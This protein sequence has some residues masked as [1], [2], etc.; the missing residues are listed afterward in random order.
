MGAAPGSAINMNA[1][2]SRVTR[3]QAGEFEQTLPL[4][5]LAQVSTPT[6]LRTDRKVRF[7]NF[8]LRF[9]LTN[10]A[11]PG[12][13]RTGPTL[14]GTGVFAIIQQFQLRGQHLRYGSQTPIIMRG[15]AAAEWMALMNPNYVPYFAVSVNG[16][17]LTQGLAL[18]NAANATN[19]VDAVLPIPLFP[20]DLS[21]SDQTFYSLHGP[22]WPG[23]LYFDINTADVTALGVT[24]AQSTIGNFGS[25]G[26]TGSIEINSERPL[27]SKQLA[28]K[29]RPGVTFRVQNAS[30]PTAAV[31]T[32][33]AASGTKLADLTVGKD[34]TRIF[35]KIGTSLA[36]TSAGVVVYGTL[37]DTIVTRFVFAMDNRVLRFQAA[38]ADS[39]NKDYAGREYGRTMPT[40]YRMIDFISGIGT[41]TGNAKAGFQSSQLTAARKFECDGDIAS[42]AATNIA[43]IVQEMVLGRPALL[44]QKAA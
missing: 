19:D 1:L 23:N 41:G 37:S 28:S 26:G 24:G 18:S 42:V 11:A 10:A 5:T 39:I 6:S 27:V 38:N 15:E 12:T 13:Y 2:L 30:Q 44:G 31:S 40:G 32:G 16:A 34:T 35:I 29:I 14:L 43:E 20:Y 21:P 22:D 17:A 33:A 36:A 25:A 7:F 3:D 4:N 8:H 9:R